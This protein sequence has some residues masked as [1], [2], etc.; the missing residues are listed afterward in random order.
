M[1]CINVFLKYFGNF[2]V[3]G[4][5]CNRGHFILSINNILRRDPQGLIGLPGLGATQ[6]DGRT[7]PEGHPS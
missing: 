5:L 4:L 1:V 7:G 2:D 6:S 3:I